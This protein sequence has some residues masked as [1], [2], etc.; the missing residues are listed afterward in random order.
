MPILYFA[1]LYDS[2]RRAY[3][4]RERGEVVLKRPA[5][6]KT[7]LL[8]GIAVALLVPQASVARRPASAEASLAV[9]GGSVFLLETEIDFDIGEEA[10][11][12]VTLEGTGTVLHDRYVLTVAHVVTQEHLEITLQT[13]RGDMTL[14]VDGERISQVTWLVDGDRRVPLRLL[15]RDEEIDAALFRLPE[16]TDLPPFPY[17]I[18]DSERLG[19]GDP[20]GLLGTD[21]Q[22]GVLYR[23]G[24]VVAL[25][26]SGAVS[27]VSRNERVFLISI[28][29]ISGESGAPVIARLGGRYELVGLA[30]GTFLGPRRLAWAIRVGPV[31][32]AL[33]RRDGS[34]EVPHSPTNTVGPRDRRP[35]AEAPPA[36]DAAR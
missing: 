24:T 4:C 2:A 12:R 25:R 21:P 28:G 30:Q 14:P 17:P 35:V 20:V 19:L 6:I 18:G 31:L 27:T 1:A 13:P 29:L 15:A 26:G 22:A 16:G 34:E 23:P 5:V 36:A 32:E 3:T 33:A 8:L 10:P 11:H 9:A 7:M